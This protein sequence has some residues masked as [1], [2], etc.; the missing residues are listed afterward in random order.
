MNAKVENAL[1]RIPSGIKGSRTLTWN[2]IFIAL[3][4]AI[5]PVLIGIDWPALGLDAK[6]VMVIM[7]VLSIIQNTVN[8]LLRLDTTGPVQG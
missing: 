2:A 5:M 4:S 7:A 6:W 8:V 3:Y 1:D